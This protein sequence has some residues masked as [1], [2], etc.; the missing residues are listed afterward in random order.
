MSGGQL[1]YYG[2]DSL[3]ESYSEDDK[4]VKCVIDLSIMTIEIVCKN[5]TV[6]KIDMKDV[7]FF[8]NDKNK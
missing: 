3:L 7:S 6:K 2:Q 5:I 4:F 8:W 1:V